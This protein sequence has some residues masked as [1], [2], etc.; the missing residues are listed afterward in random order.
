MIGILYKEG[1]GICT[2]LL[3][4][5]AKKCDFNVKR[6]GSLPSTSTMIELQR[7]DARYTTK[8]FSPTKNCDSRAFPMYTSPLT[9]TAFRPEASLMIERVSD[10]IPYLSERVVDIF[11]VLSF[12]FVWSSST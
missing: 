3:N 11:G 12:E 5:S 6:S 4:Y 8:T 7:L 10:F 1:S 2:D 9:L